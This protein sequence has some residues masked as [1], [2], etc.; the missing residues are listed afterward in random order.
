MNTPIKHSPTS[1]TNTP[2]RDCDIEF[3]PHVHDD[4]ECA[5]ILDEMENGANR[6]YEAYHDSYADALNREA[7][8]HMLGRPLFPNEY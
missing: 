7:E 4:V 3:G 2:L 8:E 1:P 6:A 5:R